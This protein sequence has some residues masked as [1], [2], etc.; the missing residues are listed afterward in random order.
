MNNSYI[1]SVSLNL[2]LKFI[3]PKGVSMSDSC[4]A[5]VSVELLP[6]ERM[7]CVVILAGKDSKDFSDKSFLFIFFETKFV[8]RCNSAIEEA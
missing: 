5:S 8:K 1:G 6:L 3:G 2:G 7:M 4:L